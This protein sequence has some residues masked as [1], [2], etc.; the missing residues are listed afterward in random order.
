MPAMYRADD[1]VH[2]ALADVGRVAGPALEVSVDSW[3]GEWTT[4]QFDMAWRGARPLP[5][6]SV[7]PP[8]SR[9]D[10]QAVPA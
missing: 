8:V 6:P 10:D 2:V 7:W 4:R 3:L 9:R 1:A 5:S